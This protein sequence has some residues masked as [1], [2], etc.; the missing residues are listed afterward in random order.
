LMFISELE[1]FSNDISSLPLK[2]VSVVVVNI[3]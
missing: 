3:V 2:V 1:L